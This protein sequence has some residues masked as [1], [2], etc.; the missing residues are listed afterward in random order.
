M[1]K[2][3]YLQKFKYIIDNLSN[4]ME[5]VEQLINDESMLKMQKKIYKENLKILEKMCKGENLNFDEIKKKYLNTKIIEESIVPK[6]NDILDVI[7]IGNTI[8]FYEN[9]PNGIVY[10]QESQKVGSWVNNNI[11]FI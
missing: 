10:N 7:N 9:K 5:D 6:T 11:S 1:S 2:L 8:Y 4:I 3:K